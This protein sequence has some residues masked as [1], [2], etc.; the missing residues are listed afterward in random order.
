M[1]HT[2]KYRAPLALYIT[3]IVP[4]ALWAGDGWTTSYWPAASNFVEQAIWTTDVYSATQAAPTTN[5]TPLLY[6]TNYLGEA[7]TGQCVTGCVTDAWA[8]EIYRALRER[9]H[10][11]SNFFGAGPYPT[12]CVPRFYIWQQSNAV[13]LK[14]ATTNLLPYFAD[15]HLHC[16]NGVYTNTPQP[17]TTTSIIERLALPTNFWSYTPWL[18]LN[19]SSNGWDNLYR[20]VTSLVWTI[21]TP[22]WTNMT[23]TTNYALYGQGAYSFLG[24][25]TL[26][27]WAEA[28]GRGLYG[29]SVFAL[30]S[31]F[32]LTQGA[33]EDDEYENQWHGYYGET[34]IAWSTNDA[35]LLS[36]KLAKSVDVYMGRGTTAN[37]DPPF[38]HCVWTNNGYGSEA[39]GFDRFATSN[40]NFGVG[41]YVGPIG[42]TSLAE[43]AYCDQPAN[44]EV[45]WKGWV[46]TSHV[47]VVKWDVT[48]GFRYK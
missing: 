46:V 10:V 7:L 33:R 37:H 32:S 12:N 18:N 19:R 17:W 30:C 28:T 25:L 22:C 44:G 42:D 1:R 21:E 14:A 34:M 38:D 4:D 24:T 36:D 45:N 20:V 8:N 11:T 39:G 6:W 41:W 35:R 27:S 26:E 29:E 13:L 15:T 31:P 3:F 5:S 2:S 9:Y 40:L 47:G 43:G 16:T 48:N 23:A